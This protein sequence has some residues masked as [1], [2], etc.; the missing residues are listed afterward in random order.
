[1]PELETL[2]PLQPRSGLERLALNDLLGPAFIWLTGG[3]SASFRQ[4]LR[5]CGRRL[6][7]HAA[8]L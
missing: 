8:S 2:S 7:E 6:R 4:R 3:R 1:M 5:Q